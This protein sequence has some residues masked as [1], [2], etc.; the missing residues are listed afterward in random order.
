MESSSIVYHAVYDNGSNKAFII[1]VQEVLNFCKNKGF[2]KAYATAKLHLTDCITRSKGA[3]DKLSE[4]M[5]DPTSSKDRKNTL[6]KGVELG[7][8]AVL[9]AAKQ[10]PKKGKNFFSLYKTLL[11]DNV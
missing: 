11:G 1:H 4:A 3:R 2:Y 8:T 9:L 10:L 6:K 7:R 5:N